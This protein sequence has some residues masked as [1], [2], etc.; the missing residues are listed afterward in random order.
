MFVPC[1]KP[2]ISAKE[3]LALN[4]AFFETKGFFWHPLCAVVHNGLKEEI[5]SA[6]DRGQLKIRDVWQQVKAVS[7]PFANET[8]FF[9]INSSIDMDKWIKTEN[10]KANLC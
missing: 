4:E 8:A 5:S 3:M 2:N 6:I 7:V 1:D 10:E 9:N